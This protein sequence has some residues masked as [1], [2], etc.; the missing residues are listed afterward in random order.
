MDLDRPDNTAARGFA[1]ALCAYAFWG[2][3]PIYIRAMVHIPAVEIVAF[4]ILFSVPVAGVILLW[5]GRTSD[6]KIALRQ[7][8]T[9]VLA[10]VTA[11]LISV[12]WGIYTWAV[13]VERTVETALGYYINPIVNIVL[14]AV[15]LGERFNKW[16]L[17]AIGLAVL[18]VIILT[19]NAG[20]LPWISLSLA[21]SFGIYGLL[22]KTLPVGAAQGFFLE[23][24]LLSVPSL[25]VLYFWFPTG[26]NHFL[27]GSLSDTLLLLAAGPATAIPLI[28]FATGA[29][30]LR[31]S[32]L[33]LM[34]YTAPTLIFLIAVFVFKEPFSTWHLVA[35][36]LIWSAL[37]IYSW[38]SLRQARAN[39]MA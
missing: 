14:G 35:F 21:F 5:L 6:L 28:L 32:T 29:K 8:R 16:Q 15:F 23:V 27:A 31:Y 2:L 30:L 34:Q 36:C 3:T 13:A 26:Q 1:I 9:L 24:L 11:C 17:A 22:R 4:R 39:A 10:G 25:A 12:N 19:L 37:T 33:G 20:G 7:P 38:S 18:A